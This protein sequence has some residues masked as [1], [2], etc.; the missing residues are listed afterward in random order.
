VKHPTFLKQGQ[1][2]IV[3]VQCAGPI[4]LE[5]F[6]SYP[7]LGRFSLR[8]EGKTVALGAVLKLCTTSLENPD[9]AHQ[10]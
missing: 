3:V 6:K 9:S 5:T 2:A 10:D 8:D 1:A 4:C 7:Q